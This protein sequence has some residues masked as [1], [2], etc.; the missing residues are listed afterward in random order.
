MMVGQ[1]DNSKTVRDRRRGLRRARRL[2]SLVR[3]H[4]G[5]Q[6]RAII[7]RRFCFLDRIVRPP[8]FAG[9][10]RAGRNGSVIHNQ[11]RIGHFRGCESFVVD[12]ASYERKLSELF[13]VPFSVK[14]ATFY[15]FDVAAFS[16]L[17]RG[18]LPT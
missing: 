4:S 5:I 10:A 6:F 8:T 17:A 9:L 18:L 12:A 3:R 13:T 15:V 11:A 2:T 14:I 7:W 1:V 16:W